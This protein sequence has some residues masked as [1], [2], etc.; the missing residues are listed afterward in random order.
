MQI[1]EWI[2]SIV[3]KMKRSHLMAPFWSGVSSLYLAVFT[4]SSAD[5]S[6]IDSL[7]TES[8]PIDLSLSE[9]ASSSLSLKLKSVCLTG[10]GAGFY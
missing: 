1:L 10:T 2:S 3:F 5:N 4:L 6:Y 9:G 8:L 7:M